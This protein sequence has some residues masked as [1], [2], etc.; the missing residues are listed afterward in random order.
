LL[1]SKTSFDLASDWEAALAKTRPLTAAI[2]DEL[3]Q[4][5]KL[6]RQ[7]A[8]SR[9][10]SFGAAAEI[11]NSDAEALNLLPPF[12]YQ[13]DVQS[14][15][16]LGTNNFQIHYHVTQGGVRVMGSFS[17]GVFTTSAKHYRI[18]GLLF[19][20]IAGI[21]RVNAESSSEGKIEQFAALRL[22]LPENME[23]SNIRSENFLLRIRMHT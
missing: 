14:R 15:G 16:A 1:R 5:G 22:L 13:L 6:R 2:I 18:A 12:P 7:S 11:Q 3:E 9:F 20:I 10:L 4:A 23:D 17:E 8:G 21:D 19:S